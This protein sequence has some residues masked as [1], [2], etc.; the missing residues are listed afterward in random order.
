MAS[1]Q[2]KSLAKEVAD[3][4]KQQ[5][6]NGVYP[7]GT[8]LPTEPELMKSF[9]VGRSTIRE[10]GKYLAQS[11]F[12][13]VKQGLGTFV[14]SQ[15]GNQALD[16]KIGKAGFS[17]VLEVRQLLELQIISKSARNRTEC[18]LAAMQNHLENRKLFAKAGNLDACIQ[19][20]IGFHTAI[21]DSCGNVILSELYKT[22]SLHLSKFFSEVYQDTMPFI[23]SQQEH[24]K[25]LQYIKERNEIKALRCAKKIIVNL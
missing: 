13:Q 12:V 11:G 19:A 5:I 20:D 25:L 15:S 7:V 18:D 17:E 21:A 2:R 1:I 8:K 10:A 4:I 3:L 24:E 23:L 22:L 16:D 14:I 6:Q 9:S